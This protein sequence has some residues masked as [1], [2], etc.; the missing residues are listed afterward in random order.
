MDCLMD[1]SLREDLEDAYET[2]LV[3]E[4]HIDFLSTISLNL[5]SFFKRAFC[6]TQEQEDA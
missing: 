1:V 2:G 3:T 5:P 6:L 4:R